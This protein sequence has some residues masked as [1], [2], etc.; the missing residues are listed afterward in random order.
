MHSSEPRLS[1]LPTGLHKLVL[2]GSLHALDP[3]PPTPVDASTVVH[4]ARH[5]DRFA[6][7]KP[8][9]RPQKPRHSSSYG[10]ELRHR[11]TS[12]YPDHYETS[13]PRRRKGILSSMLEHLHP[14][15]RRDAVPATAM[16]D[17]PSPVANHL[18]STANPG[19]VQRSVHLP[20]VSSSHEHHI[21]SS[22]RALAPTA[23]GHDMQSQLP[24]SQSQIE[25]PTEDRGISSEIEASTQQVQ[26]SA[27]QPSSL[28]APNHRRATTITLGEFV[29]NAS[30]HNDRSATLRVPE[31]R[32]QPLGQHAE[33]FHSAASTQT[34]DMSIHSTEKQQQLHVNR[35]KTL[36]ENQ[37]NDIEQ[38]ES[39]LKHVSLAQDNAASLGAVNLVEKTLTTDETNGIAV[40][41][42]FQINKSEKAVD[43][44]STDGARDGPVTVQKEYAEETGELLES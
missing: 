16:A 22:Q 11:G 9:L 29:D 13:V 8:L 12:S 15:S 28:V 3:P 31:Q 27:I 24:D 14:Y 25:L 44:V 38:D 18:S 6:S 2:P 39:T 1:F 26:H 20:D 10:A 4:H 36:D 43:I 35:E 34:D 7:Q 33:I 41:T 40:P 42:A 23:P 30:K 5:Y 17:Q 19:Q 37:H 21:R 32:E